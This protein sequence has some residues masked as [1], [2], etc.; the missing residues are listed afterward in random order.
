MALARGPET[1]PGLS[2]EAVITAML[3]GALGGTLAALGW[4]SGNTGVTIGGGVI[5]L[6][7]VIAGL[8]WARRTK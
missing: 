5:V 2:E 3:L 6:L 1:S 7:G 8:T 4:L